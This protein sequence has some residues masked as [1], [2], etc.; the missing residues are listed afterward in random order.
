MITEIPCKNDIERRS[1][2]N[3][4]IDKVVVHEDGKVDIYANIF[5]IKVSIT[6]LEKAMSQVQIE[7][8]S[9]RQIDFKRRSFYGTPF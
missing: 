8:P 9:A 4:V 6:T 7:Q 3:R 1:F 5:G 2:A